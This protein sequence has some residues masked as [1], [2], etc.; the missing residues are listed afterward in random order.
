[1]WMIRQEQMDAFEQAALRQFEREMVIHSKEFSPR[2]CK[3]IADEQLLVTIRWAIDRASKYGF[4]CRGPIRLFIEMMFL[5]G[6]GFDADPQYPWISEVL[7]TQ[8]DEMFRAQKIHEGHT[9]YLETVCGPKAVYL[10]EALANLFAFAHAPP[11]FCA[12]SV[13]ADVSKAI[14]D[15]YPQKALHIGEAGLMALIHEGLREAKRY[16]L[17]TVRHQV[18][19]IALMF[20]F[21]HSCIAD[22]LRPWIGQTLRDECIGD[23]RA[24]VEHLEMKSLMLLRDVVVRNKQGLSK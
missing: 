1:M 5:L 21:G 14:H 15:I 9:A 6:C 10:H 13:I 24:R 22:P 16:G 17:T 12:E 19:I 18:L 23:S 2:V 8:G 3:E 4:T 7:L 11:S 20:G